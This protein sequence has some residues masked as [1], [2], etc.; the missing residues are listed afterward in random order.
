MRN[1]L[2]LRYA[3]EGDIRFI[4]HNDS[5]RLFERAVARAGI[6]V[7]YSQGFNPR[8]RVRIAL[9]RPV[10]VAS[11]D[12]LL[13]VELTSRV[14]PSDVL[15]GLSTQVPA[16][17]TL[18]SAESVADADRRLPCEARYALGLEPTMSEPVAKRTAQF[19]SRD[20]VEVDRLVVKRRSRKSVNIRR[21]VVTMSV[22]ENR[23]RWTQSITTTGT[24][25]VDEVLEVLRLPSRRYLHRLRRE[26][27][28]YHP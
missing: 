14:A 21:Y 28:S 20:C 25:R 16:G 17:I 2:A 23:L 11:F 3:V 24:A 15:S 6:P 19:M 12:E 1:R 10:G 5:L 9:P 7:R 26:K 8:P 18:L 27:V 22:K 4:S 13:V